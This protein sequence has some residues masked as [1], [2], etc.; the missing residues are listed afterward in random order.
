MVDG[1]TPDHVGATRRQRIQRR[2][3][4]EILDAAREELRVHGPSNVTMRAVARA[5]DMTPSGLYRHVSGHDELLGLLAADAYEAVG[6]EMAQARDRAPEGEHATA[7]YLVGM[8]MRQWYLDHEPEY[9]LLVSPRLIKDP[10]DRLRIAMGGT[11]ELLARICSDAIEAGQL[12]PEASGFPVTS[13]RARGDIP[14]AAQSISLS[15]LAAMSGHLGF[16]T[17]GVFRQIT[18]DPQ[19]YFSAYLRALMTIMGF[20]V[21]PG[22]LVLADVR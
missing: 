3:L 20:T 13:A 11:L 22:P 17:R 5:V 9:E 18:M 4:R 6:A 12:D 14:A 1:A 2:N 16:E 19:H 15:A 21:E 8:A 10:P 7:W